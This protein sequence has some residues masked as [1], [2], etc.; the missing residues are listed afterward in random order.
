MLATCSFSYRWNQYLLCSHQVVIVFSEDNTINMDQI[1][2]DNGEHFDPQEIEEN[3]CCARMHPSLYLVLPITSLSI[4]IVIFDGVK[5]FKPKEESYGQMKLKRTVFLSHISQCITLLI[6]VAY[7]FANG[8][9]LIISIGSWYLSKIL[10]FYI[11]IKRIR[12]TFVRSIDDI[13]FK[14]KVL[15]G[16]LIIIPVFIVLFNLLAIHSLSI[17]PWILFIF[18]IISTILFS[19]VNKAFIRG[20]LSILKHEFNRDHYD[21]IPSTNFKDCGHISCQ[22][23]RQMKAFENEEWR[24]LCQTKISEYQPQIYDVIAKYSTLSTWM[25]ICL[26]LLAIMTILYIY[27][28]VSQEGLLVIVSLDCFIDILG[29]VLLLADMNKYYTLLCGSIINCHYFCGCCYDRYLGYWFKSEDLRAELALASL[30]ASK[31]SP[32]LKDGNEINSASLMDGLIHE[33][34]SEEVKHLYSNDVIKVI[35]AY[36]TPCSTDMNQIALRVSYML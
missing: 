9:H 27:E 6:I 2:I 10:V 28:I 31:W 13:P 4:F 12:R 5:I 34:I 11:T 26:P 36:A 25:S 22:W 35:R 1:I 8:N 15:M 18:C 21:R 29:S 32:F 20:L 7:I 17:I 23:M 14:D 3:L 33:S 24:K 30:R 19:V 16:L